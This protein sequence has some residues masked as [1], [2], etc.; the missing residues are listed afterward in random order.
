MLSGKKIMVNSPFSL[1]FILTPKKEHLQMV[2]LMLLKTDHGVSGAELTENA[3]SDSWTQEPST[4]P[5]QLDLALAMN[6]G[7]EAIGFSWKTKKPE[8]QSPASDKRANK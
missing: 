7:F 8:F 5:L 3:N 6:W 4:W 1:G 2:E